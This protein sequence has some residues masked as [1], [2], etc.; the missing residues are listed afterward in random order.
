M[1][2]LLSWRR[3]AHVAVAIMAGLGALAHSPATE[4][5]SARP[6]VVFILADDLGWSDT[7]L[8]RTNAFYETPNLERLARRG[9]R[10][11]QAY[12]ANP[13]CSPTRASILTGLYPARIGIT[14]P[15]CHLPQEI[16]HKALAKQ[17]GPPQAAVPAVS[18]TRLQTNYYTL[19]KALKQAGYA[20]GH[21][22]KWHLGP[23]PYSPLQQGFD[24]DVPHWPGP[25][26]A[27]CYLAPW[28]SPRFQ[29]PAKP[30]EHVEDLMA[31]Q[32]IQFIRANRDRPF[33][34]NYW[35]FSVHAPFQG[36]PELVE[37]YRAK[38]AQLP[39]GSPQRH[40]IYGAMVQSL[41][42]NV[43]RLIQ[44]LDE[45]KL[46]ENTIIIFA[47][48]NGGV[49]W[50]ART[51]NNAQD[52]FRD[53]PITSNTPLRGGKATTYEGGTREPC[54][55]IWPGLTKPG[56]VNDSIIQSTDFFPTFAELLRLQV[57]AGLKFDGHS[58][59]AALRGEAFDR[60]P[61]FCHFPHNTPA[62]GGLASTYVREGDWKLIR[63]YCLNDDRTDRLE[64]YNLREDL[65][66]SHN[67]AVQFPERVQALNALIG[68]FL[69]DTEAVVP[70][71]NPRYDPNAK[72][73]PGV[74]KAKRKGKAKAP[75][76]TRDPR[77]QL[78]AESDGDVFGAQSGAPG[79]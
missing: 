46:A 4:A 47:S 44:A 33:F 6:N 13:L 3:P 45:M 10:F 66:E 37:K 57:P 51:E 8:N 68:D 65:G 77:L 72:P 29:L 49:H 63:F 32:A 67:L 70:V 22:G 76:S 48:D 31:Q 71:S 50:S 17:A 2:L 74:P 19:A 78:E 14:A 41:D 60:G 15:T 23:E 69:K 59:A 43:G 5:A 75:T 20:T 27:G 26:P 36:K 55:V 61:T 12:A 24:V 53:I 42:E 25:G 18:L 35:A 40:P 9:M 38:A 54:L 34:L 62:S 52:D 28:K 79:G 73:V 16:L 1:L 11:T 56:S 30:D 39:P 58:F 7:T 64:L 21:F